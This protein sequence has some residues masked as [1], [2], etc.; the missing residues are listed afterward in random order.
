MS[1]PP[2]LTA[3]FRPLGLTLGLRTDHPAVLAAAEDAFRGFG[4]A[5][6]AG[7]PDLDFLFLTRRVPDRERGTSYLV[8]GERVRLREGGSTLVVDRTQGTARGRFAPELLAQ[9]AR[10]RLELLELALQLQLPPRGFLGVHGGAVV[11][12]GR[13]ALLRAQG[14]G[15]KTTL[16]YAAASRR[17]LQVLAEDV[18]WIDL[19]RG[20]R[21]GREGPG[22]WWGLP[23]WCHLRPDTARFF[24]ELAGLA[25]SLARN[26]VP[27]LAVALEAVRPESTVPR[28]LP[29]PV[30][31][32][33]RRPGTP[34]SRLTAL[35]L[36]EALELWRTG[37]AGTEEEVPG[38]S[39]YV[40]TLLRDNAWRLDLGDDPEEGL[41]RI[42][43]L[44]GG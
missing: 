35:S 16:V 32:L 9:P 10:L 22:A 36:R 38:Y 18:V 27:K 8:H 41:A 26:G 13:A 29:G 44:L 12:Q 1:R 17:S 4:S 24:P 14:G 31:L 6:P 21:G 3:G 30:V 39:G 42:E 7:P 11:H 23:W 20:V 43:E 33:H 19:L 28:A 34:A 15:G 37:R 2:L 5:P 40:E 25:P